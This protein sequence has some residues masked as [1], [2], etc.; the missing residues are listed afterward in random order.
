MSTTAKWTID[1]THS[2]INFKVK[3][4]MISN[5]KGEFTEFEAE[6]SGEDFTAS[7][8]SAKVKSDSIFTN[9]SDRDAHLKSEDFFDASKHEFITFEGTKLTKVDDDEY[10]LE[11]DLTIKDTTKNIALLLEYGGQMK[12]PYGNEKIGFS[13][14]GKINRKD[15]GLNWNAA[16]EAGGVMVSDE[17]KIIGELQ[18]VKQA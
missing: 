15:W 16:L 12:D 1:P 13:V 2:E 5:V 9:N 14:N 11:G 3:H 4:L 6:I 17:V 8:I 7:K 18:F 10:S